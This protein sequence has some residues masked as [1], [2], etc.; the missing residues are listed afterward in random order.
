MFVQSMSVCKR[1]CMGRKIPQMLTIFYI[2]YT[3]VML[4]C[5]RRDQHF[6]DI[7]KIFVDVHGILTKM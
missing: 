7:I 5:E 6:R 3:H 4:R 2:Q 1:R